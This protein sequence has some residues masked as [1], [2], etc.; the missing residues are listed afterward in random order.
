MEKIQVKIKTAFLFTAILVCLIVY[1]FSA[2]KKETGPEFA[3]NIDLGNPT[4][5][6]WP[7]EISIVGDSGEKGQASA[8]GK[9]VVLELMSENGQNVLVKIEGLRVASRTSKTRAP[10]A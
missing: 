4:A 5:I 6:Q 8:E 7:C 10:P 2:V 1:S 3:V 9:A